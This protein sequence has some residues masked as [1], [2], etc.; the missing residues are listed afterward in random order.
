MSKIYLL[1]NLKYEGVENLEVFK[2]EFI[3]S[4][5][6]LNFYDAL[7]FT[8][9]NAIYSLNSFNKKWKEIPSYAIAPMTAKIIKEEGGLVE[10]I[11]SSG[12][13]NDFAKEL[14][15]LLK[16]KKVLYIRAQKVVSKLVE[17]LKENHIDTDE[18]ITYKTVCNENLNCTLEDNSTIIFTSPSSVKC[19]FKK[20]SW[21][22]TFK[23]VVIGKTTGKFMPNEVNYKISD[24]TSVEECVKLAYK[25]TF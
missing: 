14:I 5:I 9:K 21:N 8:S 17:I 1:N 13:G 20:F 16:D 19:F 12:H 11:G 10:Y 25:L 22:E 2:I 18:L 6:D 3:E 24:R 7:L 23:A 15:P 4:D